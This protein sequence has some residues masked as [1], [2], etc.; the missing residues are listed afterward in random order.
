MRKTVA[1][2]LLGWGATAF[3]PGYALEG[4][5]IDRWLA[6]AQ[7]LRAWSEGHGEAAP[8]QPRPR[9]LESG[10]VESL[11]NEMLE[12]YPEAR[13][14]VRSHGY[15]EPAEWAETGEQIY[16]AMVAAEA[17]GAD[18]MRREMQQALRQVDEDP[19]LSGQEK[20]RLRRQIQQQMQDMTGLFTGVSEGDRQAVQARREAI[21]EIMRP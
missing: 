2:I 19:R 11:L 20:T 8:F 4:G 5:E 9:T 18:D 21:L 3:S 17:R 7:E 16:R 1:A 12:R 6:S 15:A 10:R 14:I 13:S